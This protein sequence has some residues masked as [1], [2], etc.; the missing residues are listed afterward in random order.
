MLI[1]KLIAVGTLAHIDFQ[2][3]NL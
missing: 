2:K 1:E 3:S